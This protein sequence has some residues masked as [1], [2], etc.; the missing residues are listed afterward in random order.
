MVILQGRTESKAG[1]A[2]RFA[3]HNFFDPILDM[4][5]VLEFISPS[6]S[7]IEWLDGPQE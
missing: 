6:H 1:L 4:D 2:F 7:G 5:E 3:E